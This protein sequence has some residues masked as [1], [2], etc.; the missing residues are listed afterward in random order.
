[1]CATIT[2]V[3]YSHGDPRIPDRF[4]KYVTVSPDGCWHWTSTLSDDGYGRCSIGGRMYPAHR[5]FY[6]MLVT[7]FQGWLQMDH[8]C[9]TEV[10][11]HTGRD[12]LH[13]RCVNPEHVRPATAWE[14]ILRGN[15]VTSH[16]RSKTHCA[17]GHPLSGSNL[18]VW[19]GHRGCRACR[20]A[21]DLRRKAKVK[22]VLAP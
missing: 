3:S 22:S 15:T 8:T 17:Q 9:H 4:W 20:R 1:M 2:D 13:R 19:R 7:T 11:P 5:M 14:N 10:C 18:Y 6:E 12:C 16:N 21:A